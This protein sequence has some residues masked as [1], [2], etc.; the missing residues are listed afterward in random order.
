M[1]RK[2][3]Y[4][5]LAA[6]LALGA[7]GIAAAQADDGAI[8]AAKA[9]GTVGEQADGYL[10]FAKPGDG[11]A[12]AAVDAI[13]IKRREIYT[14]IA[15]KKGTTVQEVAAAR[16]CDQLVKRVAAGQVYKGAGGWE[17]KGAGPAHLPPVCG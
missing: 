4:L 10:G 2:A 1:V 13:N 14:D 5:G 17:T 16:G 15:A 3:G 8:T 7:A 11:A 12:R 6:L 9:A